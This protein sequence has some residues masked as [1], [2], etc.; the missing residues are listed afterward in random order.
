MAADDDWRAAGLGLDMEDADNCSVASDKGSDSGS[1]PPARGSSSAVALGSG[2]AGVGD[3][4]SGV[5]RTLERLPAAAAGGGGG[6]RR[7]SW[8]VGATGMRSRV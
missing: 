2:F 5:P 1:S 7:G 6:L 8:S 4:R 3:G